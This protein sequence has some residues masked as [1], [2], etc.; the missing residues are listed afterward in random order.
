VLHVSASLFSVLISLT[1][2]TTQDIEK[3]FLL[4]NPRL[5]HARFST[6]ARL[7]IYL[8]EPISFSDQLSDQ[9]AFFLFQNIF[10]RYSTLEFFPESKISPISEEGRS[11]F[12]A[13][14]SFRDNTN[15]DRFVFRV[16]FLLQKEK[17]PASVR[18]RGPRPPGSDPPSLW[19]ITEIKAEKI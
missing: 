8:P 10:R 19:K 1:A 16:F 9:Q 17:P 18:T 2:L 11:F 6:R 12:R 5:I 3:S 14:W 13:R 15:N 4:N 7:N